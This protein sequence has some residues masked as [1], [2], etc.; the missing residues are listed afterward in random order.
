MVVDIGYMPEMSLVNTAPSALSDTVNLEDKMPQKKT[1]VDSIKWTTEISEAEAMR[2][3][4][5]E[6]YPF[7]KARYNN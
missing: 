3:M 7:T 1:A 2:L 5:V 4:E 6:M